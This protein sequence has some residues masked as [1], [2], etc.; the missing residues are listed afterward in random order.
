MNQEKLK[1]STKRTF[2]PGIEYLRI[3]FII[4][5]IGWH[6]HVLGKATFYTFPTEMSLTTLMYFCVFLLGVPMF[7]LVSQF[8]YIKNRHKGYLARRLLTLIIFLFFWNLVAFA[9]FS[10]QESASSWISPEFLIRGGYGPLY[11]IFDLI[12]VTAITEFICRGYER[13]KNKTYLYFVYLAL[14][15]ITAFVIVT[16]FVIEPHSFLSRYLV[17]LQNFLNYVP[18][19]LVAFILSV[20][21]NSNQPRTSNVKIDLAKYVFVFSIGFLIAILE[22]AILYKHLPIK[23]FA[24]VFP[25][26][27]RISPIILSVSVLTLFLKL[28]K[29]IHQK[30]EIIAGLASGV[31][32]IHFLVIDLLWKNYRILYDKANYHS[33]LFFLFI[34]IIS[35]AS[36]WIIKTKRIV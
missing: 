32:I 34:L 29:P 21:I 14:A 27:N 20:R 8:L 35:Y 11:F 1:I 22:Y 18:Y 4:L 3:I 5:I 17:N 12:I 19:G 7:F 23:Y 24:E 25:Y 36:A 13:F 30:L 31:F 28:K 2:Y 15:A 10:K 6:S 9:L 26:Y 16:P 33:V